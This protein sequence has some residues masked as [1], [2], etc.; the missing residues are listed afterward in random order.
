M[1]KK[2]IYVTALLA[3]VQFGKSQV[4]D[5]G[6]IYDGLNAYNG[7]FEN[8]GTARY[9][10]MG[11][12]MGALGGDMSAVE[13]NPA[14]L[15]I[16]KNS[17][18]NITLGVLSNKNKGSMK[19][20]ESNTDTNFNF[21]NAG[22]ALALGDEADRLKINL[23]IN[24]SYQRLDNDVL[25]PYNESYTYTINGESFDFNSYEQ[26][27]DGYKSKLKFSIATNYEDVL[28]FGLGLDWHYLTMDRLDSYSDRK[29]SDNSIGYFYRQGTPYSQDANGFGLSVGVIGKIIPELR[30][31]AA[32]H[33][34]I[35]WS[36]I[37]T[38]YNYFNATSSKNPTT[39]NETIKWDVYYGYYDKY[40]VNAPGKLALSAAYASN[41]VNDDNSLAVNVDFINYFNKDYEFKGSPDYRLNNTFVDNYMRNSQ[42]YRAGI[43]YRFK[44]L[45]LRAGYSYMSSPVKDNTIQG[46]NYET[47][48]DNAMVKNYMAG[49]KNKFSLGMG[50]D[51][52]PFFA[53]FAYQFVK[54]DYYTSFSGAY[55][56]NAELRN[57]GPG[58]EGPLSPIFNTPTFGK[59]K[60]TQNN[61]VLT[62][63]MRF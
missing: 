25:F 39:G 12:S 54:T 36:D 48:V 13:T 6:S 61:F 60:N 14:G 2:L 38:D 11:E 29:I 1:N 23:G 8:S 46:F 43:E 49:E 42:E 20:T 19:N 57:F 51:V 32:Y 44:E 28:Y 16:F 37:D 45:K 26:S 62:L 55:Y 4:F 58:K 31:G 59:I 24:Y 27:V 33:S 15:G 34:P 3:M 30:V 35:W 22:F 17:V 52:G 10:G 9:I 21:S 56:N 7:S 53:D 63:G 47:G 5:P 40:K 50:Y 18:A 41:I